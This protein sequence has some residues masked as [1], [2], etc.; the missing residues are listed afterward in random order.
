[1]IFI[2]LNFITMKKK[3][4]P[5]TVFNDRILQQKVNKSLGLSAY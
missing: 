1:M 5:K 3:D 2:K 4:I